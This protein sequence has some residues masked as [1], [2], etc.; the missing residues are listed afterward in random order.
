MFLRNPFRKGGKT[1]EL[2]PLKQVAKRK[3]PGK[4]TPGKPPLSPE[5]RLHFFISALLGTA[6]WAVATLTIL[7]QRE[8]VPFNFVE[9]QVVSADYYSEVPFSHVDIDA[10]ERLREEARQNVAPVFRIDRAAIADAVKL[11][12]ITLE[13]LLPNVEGDTAIRSAAAEEVLGKVLTELEKK[14]AVAPIVTLFKRPGARQEFVDRIA[15]QLHQGIIT[16]KPEDTFFSAMKGDDTIVV[17]DGESRRM[18]RP[19]HAQ[20][21]RFQ[22]A[23]GVRTQVARSVSGSTLS[24]QL[25]AET[26]A[27]QILRPTLFFDAKTTAEDRRE[28]AAGVPNQVVL[29]DADVLLI[30]RGSTVTKK[31]LSLI[32]GHNAVLKQ[33]RETRHSWRQ[34]IFHAGIS[35]CLLLALGYT[36]AATNPGVLRETRKLAMLA[37]LL[38]FQLL[39]TRFFSGVYYAH[40]SSGFLYGSVVPLAAGAMLMSQLMG[41]R[42]TV[43]AIIYTSLIVAAQNALSLQLFLI[44][45]FS[46]LVG[47]QLFRRARKRLH[48]LQAAAGVATAV[49]VVQL[50]FLIENQ[51]PFSLVDEVALLAVLNG[52]AVTAVAFAALPLLE[53]LFGVTTDISLLELSDLNHPLLQ[54]LQMEAPGTYHHSLM[55]ATIAEHA[56][57]AIG[58]NP[59]LARVCA[60][61][62]DIGKLSQPEYFTENMAFG[63]ST[64]H[65]GLRPRMSS[66]VILNHVR[67]GLALAERYK[68]RMV[69]REA[70]AQHHGTSLISYFY[71]RAKGQHE[72]AKN[73]RTPTDRDY[74]YPGPPPSRK[75]VTLLSIADSCEAA[76]RSLEKPTPQKIEN[77]VNELVAKKIA[78][79]QLERADLTF[80]ELAAAKAAIVKTLVNMFHGRIAYPK[81]EKE[82]AADENP[83]EK[84]NPQDLPDEP[85]GVDPGSPDRGN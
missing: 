29:I 16:D 47:A 59:L 75:E 3:G 25:A 55:V 10:T 18:R 21:T 11:L 53:Y 20:L 80:R 65:D 70:I 54:R 73:D 5:K 71:H 6:V 7:Q 27:L 60:Y 74:R 30:G 44:S 76:S 31:I 84:K 41:M 56:A 82:K 13:R 8:M 36:L 79:G 28:A 12:E 46:C 66:L 33:H 15:L 40:Y 26:L 43:N 57:A 83:A 69:I 77:L 45:F 67:E 35:L 2:A 51:I 37:V 4:K 62:H 14:D 39:F 22:A 68:L 19:V 64:P 49:V 78:D 61:F 48:S 1:G 34:T 42:V 17:L 50:L 85:E 58:A 23:A 32:N 24:E 63:G 72:A 38:C 9:G 52:F 81:S